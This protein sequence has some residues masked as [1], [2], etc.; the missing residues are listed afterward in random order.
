[1]MASFCAIG[2]GGLFV[3]VNEINELNE[4]D[5]YLRNELKVGLFIAEALGYFCLFLALLCIVGLLTIILYIFK[6]P[7]QEKGPTGALCRKE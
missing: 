4:I 7:S 3:L 2:I 1:M 5:I 6:Q